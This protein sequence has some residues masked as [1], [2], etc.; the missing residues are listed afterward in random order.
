MYAIRSYY[1]TKSSISE[2]LAEYG[3]HSCRHQYPGLKFIFTIF[4]Y[5]VINAHYLIPEFAEPVPY[6]NKVPGSSLKVKA[7]IEADVNA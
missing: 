4:Q 6:Q 2:V 7:C 1:G 5:S 3:M